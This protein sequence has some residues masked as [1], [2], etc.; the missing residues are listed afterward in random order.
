MG[1]F[2]AH[3]SRLS[4][5]PAAARHRLGKSTLVNRERCLKQAR[6]CATDWT[7]TSTGRSTRCS[8]MK[9]VGMCMQSIAV[10]AGRV[11]TP[12]TALPVRSSAHAR[13]ASKRVRAAM[14]LRTT[15]AAC[16]RLTTC[17]LHVKAMP[18]AD[19]RPT[20]DASNWVANGFAQP[21]AKPEFPLVIDALKGTSRHSVVHVPAQQTLRSRSRVRSKIRR[22]YA[23]LVLRR[24]MRER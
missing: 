4:S 7:M 22:A 6:S 21:V 23:V 20:P 2:V 1:P 5:C 19:L 24:A 8:A 9:Q 14:R 18:I 17:A 12:M 3:C 15:V 16:P 10:R 13:G 11:A